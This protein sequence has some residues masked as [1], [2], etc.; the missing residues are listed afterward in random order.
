MLLIYEKTIL[1]KFIISLVT[2]F[3]N[4]PDEKIIDIINF[5]NLDIPD[6]IE[7]CTDDEIYIILSTSV[8]YQAL[9]DKIPDVSP[10]KFLFIANVKDY[11]SDG[12]DNFKILNW[13]IY[14]S[15]V[16]N[17][18]KSGKCYYNIDSEL[19]DYIFE[20]T[21][22]I[23]ST[24]QRRAYE[25]LTSILNLSR[26]RFLEILSNEQLNTI[27]TKGK[28]QIEQKQQEINKER[29]NSITKVIKKYRCCLCISNYLETAFQILERTNVNIVLLAEINLKYDSVIMRMIPQDNKLK[30]EELPLYDL[31]EKQFQKNGFIRIFKISFEE[32]NNIKNI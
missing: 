5:D 24:P 1:N 16:V 31:F 10:V 6:I 11:E 30:D 12:N 25:Y 27:L 15:N 29:D 19:I 18:L 13:H 22:K 20:F 21:K 32:F 3:C 4:L 9:K 14:W 7:K 17:N 23:P 8:N 26:S 28:L 2:P